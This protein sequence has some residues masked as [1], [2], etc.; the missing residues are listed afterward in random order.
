MAQHLF[1]YTRLVSPHDPDHE[2]PRQ[3]TR[4]HHALCGF[5]SSTAGEFVHTGKAVRFGNPERVCPQCLGV[6]ESLTGMSIV[7]SGS[8][9]THVLQQL[10]DP[11]FSYTEIE[12]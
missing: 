8:L 10:V 2:V 11:E 9:G 7:Q 5:T 12:E 6:V 1:D 4:V 3:W